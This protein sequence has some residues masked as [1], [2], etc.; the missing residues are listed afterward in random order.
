MNLLD[1]IARL[2]RERVED[3]LT[4]LRLEEENDA[5]KRTTTELAL[6][7]MVSAQGEGDKE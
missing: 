3:Q 7:L 2:K 5:L 6:R 1:E 4:I